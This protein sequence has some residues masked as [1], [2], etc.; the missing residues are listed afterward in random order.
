MCFMDTLRSQGVPP[1]PWIPPVSSSVC[2]ACVWWKGSGLK[3]GEREE[4]EGG[5]VGV[6]F[7]DTYRSFRAVRL[8]KA[9][10]IFGPGC[11]LYFA[12]IIRRGRGS[13]TPRLY[14]LPAVEYLADREGIDSKTF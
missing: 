13:Q 6:C 10:K 4:R 3:G 7:M 8:L 12:L 14:E 1:G 11:N 9:C 2:A 5:W